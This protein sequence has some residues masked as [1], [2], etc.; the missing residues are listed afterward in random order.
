[1]TGNREDGRIKGILGR[2]R[3]RHEALGGEEGE[4]GEDGGC[5]RRRE[6]G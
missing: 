4:E 3:G 6:G 2:I 1:M 5:Q